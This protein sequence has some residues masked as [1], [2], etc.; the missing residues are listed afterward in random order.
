VP[1]PLGFAS[2]RGRFAALLA[3]SSDP[4]GFASLRGPFAALLAGR[5]VAV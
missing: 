4:T 2:L 1:P 3:G 5:V